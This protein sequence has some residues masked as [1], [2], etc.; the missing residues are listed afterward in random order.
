MGHGSYLTTTTTEKFYETMKIEM[1]RNGLRQR[2]KGS[3][4]HGYRTTNIE[5]HEVKCMHQH[6]AKIC[7]N[8]LTVHICHGSQP[9]IKWPC[10][11]RFKTCMPPTKYLSEKCERQAP[12]SRLQERSSACA[13]VQGLPTPKLLS[14]HPLSS[15]NAAL[16]SKNGVNC[17]IQ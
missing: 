4:H 17:Q 6:G 11:S 8:L 10:W 15:W 12:F 2:T 14:A 13:L 1:S 3:G 5:M 16:H 9:T 7:Y